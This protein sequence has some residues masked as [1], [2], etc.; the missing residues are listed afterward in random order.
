MLK[1]H[2]LLRTSLAI[3]IMV[4]SAGN[5]THANT[6]S[7]VKPVPKAFL[8]KWVGLHDTQQKLTKTVLAD[9]CENG[10]EQDT[11]YFLEFDANEQRATEVTY[12]EDIVYNYPISYSTYTKNHIAGQLL[13]ISFEMGDDD[14]LSSKYVR[15]FDYKIAGGVLTY[16]SDYQTIKMMRCV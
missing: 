14:E 5:V 8:G 15:K 9:L 11:S 6:Q 3:A 13:S 7:N 1:I 2:L 10:G 12:W 16:T 4:L